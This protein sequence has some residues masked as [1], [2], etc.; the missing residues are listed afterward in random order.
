VTNGNG[1]G[2]LKK[3]GVNK[4]L[5]K[6]VSSS[7]YWLLYVVLYQNA[8]EHFLVLLAADLSFHQMLVGPTQ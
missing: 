6:Y 1:V 3:P 4:T 7:Y 2:L 8:M 5:P